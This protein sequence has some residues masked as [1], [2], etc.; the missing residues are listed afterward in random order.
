[1]ISGVSRRTFFWGVGGFFAG[2]LMTRG[3]FA[4]AA[5]FCSRDPLVRSNAGNV[6]GERAEL[7]YPP[8][9][10]SYFEKQIGYRA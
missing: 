3:V 2:V 10:L 1:V 7:L 6:A 8:M 4:H 5:D 9:D